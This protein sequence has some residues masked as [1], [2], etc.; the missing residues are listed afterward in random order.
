MQDIKMAEPWNIQKSREIY[1]IAHWGGGYFDINAAGQVVA[2]RAPGQGAKG[3]SLHQV[4]EDLKAQGLSLP[5]LVRFVDVLRHRVDSL[6][7]A[8]EQ[9]MAR[10]NYSGTYTAVYPIKV[11]QNQSVVKEIFNHGQHRVGLEAGSK[12]ELLAVLALSRQNGGIVVCN[13]YKDREYIRLAL[14]GLRLGHRVYIVIEKRSELELVLEESARLG[15]RP[16]IGV[17][18]RLSSISAGK[19]QNSGGEKAK[20]GLSAGQVIKMVER[21]AEVQMLD[22]LEL[23][24]C[25]LGS[26]I[27][28]IRDIQQGMK[29]CARFYAELRRLGANITTVDV[30]GGLGVDYEGTRSRSFCSANYSLEEYARNI[31][32]VIR[33]VCNEVNLPHPNIITESGRAMT[34]HH[35][36]LITNVID[37]ESFYANN[38]IAPL[39]EEELDDVASLRELAHNLAQVGQAAT[40][41]VEIYHNATHHLT[42]IQTLYV[43]GV[44]TLEQRAVAERLY[45]ETCQ[46]LRSCLQ[47]GVRNQREIVDELNEKLADKYFCNFSLFQS[48]PDVWAIGQIFPVVPLMRLDEEPTRRGVVEDITCDSDGRI[49]FYVDGEGVEPSLPLHPVRENEPYLLGVF[50]VGAYQEILG[51]MHNLF[52]DTHSVNIELGEDGSYR[53]LEQRLGD[54]VSYVLSYVHFERDELIAAYEQKLA[55]SALAPAERESYLE[56]LVAGLDG[57]TYLED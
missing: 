8:F 25:H 49:D 42:E 34:A 15:I 47:P 9:A 57:Y 14:I 33:D 7:Q 50:L 29:E 11:N 19:W 5:V 10:K 32:A 44:V 24:H 43:H 30:G 4:A 18:V 17:R 3:V 48:M 55:K 54:S 28:N 40:S 38:D 1:N 20:F 6:C 51:D 45:L 46:R 52:G 23:L 35:A 26:Q 16:L 12:P 56:E 36:V 22:C 2:L 37:F 13:G 21:L 39:S 31:V 27:A 41:P 53:L